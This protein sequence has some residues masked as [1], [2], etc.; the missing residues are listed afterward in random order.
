MVPYQKSQATTS[1]SRG[2]T[3]HH[4]KLLLKSLAGSQG[5]LREVWA[6]PPNYKL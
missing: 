1:I 5:S 3:S 2:T 6:H 4:T